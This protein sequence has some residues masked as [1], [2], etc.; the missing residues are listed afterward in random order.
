MMKKLMPSLLILSE[1]EQRQIA[2]A[3]WLA[4][5]SGVALVAAAMTLSWFEN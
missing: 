2:I 1:R 4:V 5:V 3:C